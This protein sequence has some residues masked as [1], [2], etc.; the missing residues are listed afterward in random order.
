MK[1]K[2]FIQIVLNKVPEINGELRIVENLFF[3]FYLTKP[4]DILLLNELTSFVADLGWRWSLQ[5]KKLYFIPISISKGRAVT[6]LKEREGI[7]QVFGAGDSILDLDFLNHCDFPFVPR[8]SELTKRRNLTKKFIITE[9]TNILSGEE[10]LKSI[11][12]RFT[13]N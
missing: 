6:F 12:R 7:S 13:V 2:E 10:I 1:I 9:Q 8:N 11:W 5:G 4:V 3:Y